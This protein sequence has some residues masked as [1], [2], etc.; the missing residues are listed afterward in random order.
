MASEKASEGN[1]YATAAFA[2]LDER[3]AL[4]PA[5]SQRLPAHATEGNAEQQNYGSEKTDCA[6][7]PKQGSGRPVV[8]V[9]LG[10]R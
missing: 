8:A 5:Y 10:C 3:D 9:C 6:R 7:A 2:T 1:N 4:S